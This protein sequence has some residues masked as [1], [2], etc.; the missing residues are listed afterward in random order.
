[1]SVLKKKKILY[2]HTHTHKEF[3]GFSKLV[4]SVRIGLHFADTVTKLMV[5]YFLKIL[6]CCIIFDENVYYASV[7]YIKD[8]NNITVTYYAIK[9]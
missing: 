2:T 7:F 5:Y 6:L 1:M 4:P 9:Q 3:D 8:D